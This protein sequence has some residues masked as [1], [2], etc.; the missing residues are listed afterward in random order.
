VSGDDALHRKR[1]VAAL[2][3]PPVERQLQ[4]AAL[5]AVLASART[6][7]ELHA[8]LSGAYRVSARGAVHGQVRRRQGSLTRG[9]VE[10][11]HTRIE[12]TAGVG[13][14]ARRRRVGRGAEQVPTRPARYLES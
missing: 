9:S 3:Q 2:E 6:P 8:A 4:A 14:A 5:P 13:L 12:L 1:A 7:L 10:S 11:S